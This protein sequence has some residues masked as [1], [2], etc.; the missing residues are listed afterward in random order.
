M[1]RAIPTP[2]D[3]FL[4]FLGDNPSRNLLEENLFAQSPMVPAPSPLQD[5]YSGGSSQFHADLVM[6]FLVLFLALIASLTL[7]S[8]IKRVFKISSMVPICQYQSNNLY[9]RL[10][11]TG[12]ELVALKRHPTKSDPQK[13]EQG[14]IVG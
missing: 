1:P 6:I 14:S 7:Y 3:L 12:F 2:S 8:L 11:Q 10:L 13:I 5:N 4:Q 9:A